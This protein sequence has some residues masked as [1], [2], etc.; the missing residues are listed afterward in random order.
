V[1]CG[2]LIPAS[3]TSNCFACIPYATQMMCLDHTPCP[4]PV[5]NTGSC[6]NGSCSQLLCTRAWAISTAP[7]HRS[8]S[9]KPTFPT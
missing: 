7:T 9:G 4:Q 2:S 6:Y 5:H 3:H 1:Y 8:H